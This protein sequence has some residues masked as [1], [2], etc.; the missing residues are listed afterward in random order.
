MRIRCRN[1]NRATKLFHT[2]L[3]LHSA[4]SSR[5]D[6]QVPSPSRLPPPWCQFTYLS[7]AK[8]A[9]SRRSTV[10]N[11]YTPIPTL[12]CSSTLQLFLRHYPSSDGPKPPSYNQASVPSRL[13]YTP[14]S[15]YRRPHSSISV[16]CVS[17]QKGSSLCWPSFHGMG[18]STSVGLRLLSV[19]N[20]V[21]GI[22]STIT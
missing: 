7:Y 4:S 11:Y 1:S 17:R 6:V 14:A 20:D 18:T 10:Q 2:N 3:S 5:P 12:T 21:D 13:A 15:L 16:V 9:R 19:G 22:E 8:F